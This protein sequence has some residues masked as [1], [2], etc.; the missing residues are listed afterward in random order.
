MKTSPVTIADIT[1]SLMSVP[2]LARNGD[3]SLNLEENRKLL[4][5]IEAAGVTS[6]LYGGNANFYAVSQRMFEETLEMLAH[7]AGEES[8]IIPSVGPDYGKLMDQAG[9]AKHSRFPTFINLPQAFG[10]TPDGVDRGIREFVQTVGRPVMVYLKTEN[11]LTPAHTARLVDE[12]VACAVKYGINRPDA[13]KDPY[14]D[15]L[16][17]MVDRARLIIVGERHVLGQHRGYKLG[18]MMSGSGTIAPTTARRIYEA[19]QADDYDTASTLRDR[20]IPLEDI[21]DAIG[22]ISVLH[23]AVSFS[24]IADMG[25]LTP[26][27]ANVAEPHRAKVRDAAQALLAFERSIADAPLAKS[28]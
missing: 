23:D 17:T 12:N 26:L 21:R 1:G 18:A 8:W 24:G 16:V 20:I 13:S 25:P 15:Q 5:H 4:R 2:P 22:P 7:V 27:V 28:A 3:L 6:H 11:Y 14:L 10:T 19:I 9:V